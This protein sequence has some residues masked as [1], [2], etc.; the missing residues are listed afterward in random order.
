MPKNKKEIAFEKK[1]N[2]LIAKAQEQKDAEVMR[3]IRLLADARKEIAAT[4][5]STEWE[6]YRIPEFKA[7]IDRAMQQFGDKYGVDLRDAQ[8]DFWETG[9]E[10][11]NVPLRTVGIY[12]A[13]PA[14]DTMALIES[15]KYSTFLVDNLGRDAA[16][17]IYNEITMGLMGQKTPFEVMRAVGRNLKDKSIFTS[18]AARAETITRTECGRVLETASQLSLEAAAKVVPGMQKQW[19]HGTGSR[20]PRP[21]HDAA[22]GQVRDVDK[23]FDVGGTKLMYPHD[24]AGGAK[25][26]INCSCYSIPYHPDWGSAELP[27]WRQMRAFEADK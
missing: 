13:L 18:I 7:A 26:T 25:E 16:A 20:I 10:M 8:R 6:I 2:E 12:T 15:Q 22:H 4:V 9:I 24:P 27:D 3:V 14:I 17:K 19:V 23:P 11:V 1:V 21:S 5:A